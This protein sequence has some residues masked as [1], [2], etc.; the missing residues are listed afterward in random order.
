MAVA[1]VPVLANANPS[2]PPE[3]TWSGCDV[4]HQCATARVPLDYDEP[5]GTQITLSLR[6]LPAAKPERRIGTLFVSPGGAGPVATNLVF[7]AG[8]A[9]GLGQQVRDRFD[10]VAFDPRGSGGSTPLR[11]E[12]APGVEPVAPIADPYPVRPEQV[13]QYLA[14]DD[15]VRRSCAATGGEILHHISTANVARDMDLLRQALGE[16]KL[17]Y[18]G[19]SQG[20]N[21]GVTYATL[22]PDRV[23]AVAVDAVLDPNAYLGTPGSVDPMTSRVRLGDATIESLRS[24]L[25]L[26]DKVSVIQCPLTGSPNV[27]AMGRWYRVL[28]SLDKQPLALPGVT[29]TKSSFHTLTTAALTGYRLAGVPL[30]TFGPFAALTKIVDTL[31]FGPLSVPHNGLLDQAANLAKQLGAAPTAGED[32]LAGVG[33]LRGLWCADSHNPADP[34]AWIEAARRD[35][36]RA[37]GGAAAGAWTSSICASWPGSAEDAYRGPI[38]GRTATPLLVINSSH[39]ATTGIDGARAARAAFEGSR[40]VEVTTWGHT[41]FGKSRTCLT[42]I[43]DTYLIERRLPAGDVKCK[44]DNGIWGLPA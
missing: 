22:F 24:A 16:D 37:P 44:A 13:D 9:G 38:G 2:A 14:R 36:A 1:T 12:P 34:R 40:L 32:L 42:P 10:I 8:L 31:R 30:D 6:R 28:E 35:E 33:G 18:Y 27:N 29:L 26:C 25:S 11:C 15:Y 20:A 3:I 17:S 7:F 43:T 19:A 41:T 21:L 5:D 23:R 4:I 39:D